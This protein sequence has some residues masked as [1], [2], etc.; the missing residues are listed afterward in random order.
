MSRAS[1]PFQ[2]RRVDSPQGLAALELEWAQLAAAVSPRTPFGTPAWATLWWRHFAERRVL[3]RDEFF[4]HTLSDDT[5]RLVAVAP[6]VLTHRP[7]VG[8]ASLRT[9]QFF[10]ADPNVTEL[11]GMICR[12]E[13]ERAAVAALSTHLAAHAKEWD[14]FKWSGIRDADVWT[15]LAPGLRVDGISSTPDYVL[16]L[17]NT[18]EE[19]RSLLSRNIKESLRKCYNSLR[20]DGHSFTFRVVGSPADARGA[21]ERFLDLHAVRARAIGTVAHGDVFARQRSRAFLFDYADRMAE[22]GSLR[23]FELEIRGVV[24]A[25]RLGFQF[26]DELYLYFSGYDTAWGRYSVMTTVL[27]E[28]IQW[29]IARGLK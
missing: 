27:S 28:A 24:V 25:T 3:I 15:A 10:G 7:G 5:G 12:P 21:M 17:P 13:D 19:F 9:I 11:R 14:W 29:A 22:V 26:G 20:R 16:A 2:V 1:R 18:W 8:A 6:L 4:V 23:V